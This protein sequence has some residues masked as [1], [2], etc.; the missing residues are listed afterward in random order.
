MA[1]II[2]THLSGYMVTLI[3]GG[4][5]KRSYGCFWLGLAVSVV[6][7]AAVIIVA[8]VVFVTGGNA[9]IVLSV[10]L[11]MLVVVGAGACIFIEWRRREA[12][13]SRDKGAVEWITKT[14]SD[15]QLNNS[16]TPTAPPHSAR[17]SWVNWVPWRKSSSQASTPSYQVVAR[18]ETR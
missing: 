3:E 15:T 16:L 17:S 6:L 2:P 4:T 13:K 5:E 11:L 18:N 10:L 14:I 9:L 8:V 12:A 7:V 1:A